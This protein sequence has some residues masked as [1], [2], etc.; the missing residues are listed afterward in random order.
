M[1]Q[2]TVVN[3]VSIGQLLDIVEAVKERPELARFRFRA[4]NKWLNAGHNRTWIKDFYGACQEDTSRAEAFTLDSDEPPV[5]LGSNKAPCP[6]ELVLHALAACLTSTLVYQA[7]ANGIELE[8]VESTLEGDIDIQGLFE[9][10][11]GVRPGYQNITVNFRVKSN[12]SAEQ[13]QQLTMLSPVLDIISNSVPVRVVVHEM[14]A[15]A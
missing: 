2:D 13:L 3:G 9:L 7:A 6:V 1:Q 14:D 15:P 10:E 4:N 5:L 12:A 8:A 11:E